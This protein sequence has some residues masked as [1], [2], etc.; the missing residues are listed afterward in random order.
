MYII[1]LS[2]HNS[3]NRTCNTTNTKQ[4]STTLLIIIKQATPKHT[5]LLKRVYAITTKPKLTINNKH[6]LYI[7]L[8]YRRI[9]LNTKLQ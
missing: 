3:N 6:N 2:L 5:I 1:T 7:I 9:Y 8:N 4:I